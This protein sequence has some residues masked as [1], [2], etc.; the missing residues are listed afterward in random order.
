MSQ[1]NIPLRIL[2][3]MQS[4]SF[5]WVA[6]TNLPTLV[7]KTIR[8]TLLSLKDLTILGKMD[9]DLDGFRGATP[10]DYDSFERNVIEQAD[11]FDL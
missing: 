11:A 2:H 1:T 6:S 8:G 9:R 10:A 3:P 4:I 7:V 5:P